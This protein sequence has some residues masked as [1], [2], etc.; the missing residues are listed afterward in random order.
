VSITRFSRFLLRTTAVDDAAAFYDAVLEGRGDGIVPL[1]ESAIAR[2]ARPHWLGHIA[3]SDLQRNSVELIEKVG[4]GDQTSRSCQ[5]DSALTPSGSR[6][7]RPSI[8]VGTAMGG[9]EAAAARFVE[10]GATRLGPASGAG[11]FV[12]LR[13]PGGAVVAVTDDAGPSSAG[14][15]WH[16]LNTADPA[17]AATSYSALFGWSLAEELDLGPLGRHRRL[18][19]RAGEPGVGLMSDI[20]GRPGVHPHW[21]FFFGV[22]SL[23]RAV[24]RVRANGGQVVATLTLPNGVRLAAFDDPQ[25]AAFG[26]I[27]P[28]DA[29]RLGRAG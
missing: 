19:F 26:V 15:A 11:D 6:I 12:V 7:G 10:H 27:E 14:V 3:V 9:A 2:G 5:P 17:R 4:G 20:E 1:H 28:E 23:G 13:D 16:Q 8:Q 18:A 21:L 22:P 25:G 29:V 24:E